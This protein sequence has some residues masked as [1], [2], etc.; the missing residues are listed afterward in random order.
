MKQQ[1][2]AAFLAAV[3]LPFSMSSAAQAAWD[4]STLEGIAQGLD[5]FWT[6][7]TLSYADIAYQPPDVYTYEG[8]GS[9]ACGPIS[10]AQYCQANNAVHLDLVALG[11]FANDIG[12]SAAYVV[13]A[14]EYAHSVQYQLGI[15]SSGASNAAL[16]LQADCLAGVFFSAA[17]TVGML[18]AGDVEEGFIAAYISGDFDFE[19]PNHHG[20]PTQRS[21]AFLGGFYDPNSCFQQMQPP[22][23]SSSGAHGSHHELR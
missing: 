22:S 1:T 12:D 7:F 5:V 16:E 20:D 9:T 15:F 6:A 2:I 13:L 23:A 14:H 10:V 4:E 19:A 8:A 18:E 11:G 3:A 21:S 17:N